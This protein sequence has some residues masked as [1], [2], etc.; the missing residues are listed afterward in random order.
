MILKQHQQHSPA[1][2]IT[3]QNITADA[4]HDKLEY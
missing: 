3:C 1:P 2:Y 4:L